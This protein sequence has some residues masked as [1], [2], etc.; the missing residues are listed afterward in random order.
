MKALGYCRVSS[1]EQIDGTSL[2]SQ[3]NQIRAYA[4]MKGVELV[5][6]FVDASVSGSK[7]LA[8]RPY[9]SKLLAALNCGHTDT[10]ILCKLDR[11]FRSASDCLT[12]VEAW[13][14]RGVSLHILNL[15]GQT[16][17]TGTPTGKFF[18]TIMAGAAEL[19]RN[20]IRERCN[21]GR[22]ARRTQGCRIGEV[23]YGYS[24]G[25]DEKILVPDPVEQQAL[26][27]IL[28]MRTQGQ[29][30][31]KISDELNRQGYR[32]KKVGAWTHGQVAGVISSHKS[33]Q[34]RAA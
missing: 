34:R 26:S 10:V 14:R 8:D 16:I 4:T 15:G 31:R 32:A 3:E 7:L 33:T 25:E 24:L 6:I 17:D 19:E 20:L 30:L 11:G 9:G 12:N 29:S 13:E 23:L 2:Q 27:L 22:R 5:N 21:E 1:Q 28:S 18:I